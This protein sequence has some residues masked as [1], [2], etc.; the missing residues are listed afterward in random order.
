VRRRTILVVTAATAGATVGA[1]RAIGARPT[2]RPRR[3]VTFPSGP[4]ALTPAMTHARATELLAIPRIQ[5]RD[6]A[7]TFAPTTLSSI[8]PLLHGRR[9]FPRILE[10]IAAATDHVHLLFYAFKPGAIGG[11]FVDLLSAKAR[12]GVQVRVAVD[13]IGSG[14]DVV[15][16]GLYRELRAAGVEVVANDGLNIVR[17]GHLGARRLSLHIED[18]FHFDHRKLAVIDGRVAYVGGSGIEDRFNDS[19]FTDVMCRLTG[20][21]VAQVQLAFLTSWLKDGGPPPDSIDGF[22]GAADGD[23]TP[24]ETDAAAPLPDLTAT[25]MMNVPGTG[26]HPIRDAVEQ[27]IDAAGSSIDIVNPYLSDRSIMRR[28]LAAAERGVTVRIVIPAVPHP[29]YPMA[30]FR[31][32][33]PAL[34][35]ADVEIL[36]YPGMVHA[37]VYRMDERLFIGSC[38]LDSLSLYRNDELDVLFEGPGVPTIAAQSVFDE[39]IDVATPVAPT[40]SRRGRAWERLMDRSSRFL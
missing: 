35:A 17:H 1:R 36:R 30:A 37:K 7:M 14:I 22:F 2:L 13:A 33:I 12:A 34:T 18:A 15:S 26:H 29:P 32:W 10:D 21:L 9:Y 19:R 5:R 20:P 3:R 31:A 39:L 11:E 40:T 38:N 28:L 16:R 27:S 23:G 8:E 4:D 6:E 24:G 25:L